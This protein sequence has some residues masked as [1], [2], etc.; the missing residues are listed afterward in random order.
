[1]WATLLQVAALI[2]FPVG[3][4]IGFGVGGL[5]VGVSVSALLVGDAIE[6]NRPSG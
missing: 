6:S 2:G 1:M 5:I 3:G 4:C